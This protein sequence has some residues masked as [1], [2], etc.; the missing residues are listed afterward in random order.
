MT[1]FDPGWYYHR[2]GKPKAHYLKRWKHA[3]PK[4]LFNSACDR[5]YGYEDM[6]VYLAESLKGPKCADCQQGMKTA[7]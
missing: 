3:E 2:L 5:L 1:T 4:Y 6:T 7:W